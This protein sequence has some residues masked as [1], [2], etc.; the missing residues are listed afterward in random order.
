MVVRMS[1]FVIAFNYRPFL[2]LAWWTRWGGLCTQH[3]M[4][5]G[6]KKTD[7]SHIEPKKI[8]VCQLRQIG[9]AI[10][11]TPSISMLKAKWP[12][13]EIHVLTEQKCVPIFENNPDVAVVHGL[14]KSLSVF[15]SLQFYYRV[16]T[17][18]FD[19]VVDFQQ[20]PRCKWVVLFARKAIRLTYTPS[21]YNAF[22]Y[23]H[24]VDSKHGYAAAAKASLLEPLGLKYAGE[25]P[26]V[27]LTD[28]ELQAADLFLEDHGIGLSDTI[29]SVDS[30]HKHKTR[31]WP[32]ER[33]AEVVRRGCAAEKRNKFILFY[34]PG[35]EAE[36]RKLH[37]M[38]DN[39]PQV[40]VPDKVLSLRE[41]AAIISRSDILIGNCSAPR[42][43]AVAVGTP[44]VVPH[45]STGGAW[46]IRADEH[47][48]L[49]SLRCNPPCNS[50]ECAHI[51][52]LWDVTA[53]QMIDS[54]LHLLHYYPKEER[55]QG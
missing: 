37:A 22:L 8:L 36:V 14:D 12:E 6:K 52:C 17:M 50:N 16:G 51:Q 41:M 42:H 2:F 54:I 15:R 10:L 45:G 24:W 47:V 48:R 18:G 31:K 9:D 5:F 1:P 40:V 53:D 23:S 28:S 11:V 29:V 20:L 34:G 38:C 55:R 13:A 32:A 43:F 44:S 33:Y 3:H 21:W 19:L 26:R 35:E 27:H 46:R 49:Q 4:F 7:I 25:Y 39:D 30:T